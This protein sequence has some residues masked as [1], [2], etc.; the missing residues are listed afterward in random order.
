[1][2]ERCADV[3]ENMAAVAKMRWRS[4]RGEE[5]KWSRR[6][7]RRRKANDCHERHCRSPVSSKVVE[8]NLGLERAAAAARSDVDISFILFPLFV[9]RYRRCH[10]ERIQHVSRPRIYTLSPSRR[11]FCPFCP[12]SLSNPHS[13]RTSEIA[14][15][16]LLRTP[17][18]PTSP[19]RRSRTLRV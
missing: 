3:G 16:W 7:D 9:A 11:S 5:A 17:H 15:K 6:G 18:P 2:K 12:S 19:P 1:V 13:T 8:E 4:G 10:K 14:E